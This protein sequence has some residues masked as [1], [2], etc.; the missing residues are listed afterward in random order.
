MFANFYAPWITH[1]PKK[2]EKQRFYPLFFAKHL[3]FSNQTNAYKADMYINIP[4]SF[5]SF[6]LSPLARSPPKRRASNLLSPTN[7]AICILKIPLPF[8][9]EIC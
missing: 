7:P 9:S 8:W 4:N 3:F 5:F 2:H 6:T 1:A